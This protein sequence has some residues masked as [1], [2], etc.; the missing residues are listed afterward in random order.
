MT[1]L[2]TN[3]NATPGVSNSTTGTTTDAY[4]AAL[5]LVC[6]GYSQKTIIIANTDTANSL[7][8]KA[9]GYANR[10]STISYPILAATILAHGDSYKLDITNPYDQIILSVVSTAAPG[11][12]ATYQIDH[13]LQRSA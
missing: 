5:T 4:V 9:D 7:T 12:P 1:S 2:K 10:D 6:L 11:S 13:V 3:N 8:F